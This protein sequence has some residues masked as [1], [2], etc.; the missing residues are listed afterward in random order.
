MLYR[1][2]RFGSRP[3]AVGEV[4]ALLLFAKACVAPPPPCQGDACE[5][6]GGGSGGETA[7][8]GSMGGIPDG[9]SGGATGGQSGS[10]SSG[11]M[12]GSGG[13]TGGTTG[14]AGG[15][16]PTFVCGPKDCGMVDD[17]CGKMLDCDA[18]PNGKVDCSSLDNW[19]G[20]TGGPM[21]CGEDHLCHCPPEG[22]SPEAMALCQGP[23]AEPAVDQWCATQGGCNTA[24]CGSASS[25]KVPLTCIG[26]GQALKPT[27]QDPTTWI[28]IWC[29]S[30]AVQ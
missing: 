18:T 15:C 22:N 3:V 14:G 25:P 1:L 28:H 6:G 19:S 23:A 20:A 21:T 27:P 12:G 24:L 2:I 7:T 10:T 4:A 8:G 16:E 11:G 13:A 26:S 17:G 5:T 30:I 9:G 29:C